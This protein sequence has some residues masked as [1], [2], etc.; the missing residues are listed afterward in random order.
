[1]TQAVYAPVFEGPDG[2]IFIAGMRAES[3][4]FPLSTWYG[5][6]ICMMKPLV[7]PD[8]YDV[9]RSIANLG[10]TGKS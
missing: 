4:Q 2:A 5:M 8:V 1:M 7:G 9:R 3:L 6:L 10:L